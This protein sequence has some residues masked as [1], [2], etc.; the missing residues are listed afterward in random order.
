M[1]YG[2]IKCYYEQA[3]LFNP[4]LVKIELVEYFDKDTQ[5]LNTLYECINSNTSEWITYREL[6]C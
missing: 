3:I 5:E 6:S 1:V 2:L 4:Y